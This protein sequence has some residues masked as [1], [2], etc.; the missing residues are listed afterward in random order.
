MDPLTGGRFA[1]RCESATD[2]TSKLV[3]RSRSH[4][5]AGRRLQSARLR[6]LRAPS[7]PSCPS[8]SGSTTRQRRSRPELRLPLFE[9]RRD[10]FFRVLALEQQLLQLALE[11]QALAEPG[12]GPDCTARL[13]RPTARLA[14]C[15]GHELARVVEHRLDERAARQPRRRPRPRSRARAPA[16]SSIDI[17]RPLTISSI[18]RA[19][20][21]SRASRCV[22]PVPGSTPSAT[23][24]RPI[25]P[26]SFCAMRRSA[27]IATS[28]PP[29]TV[30]PF[31]AAITSFGVC[32]SRF[33]VSLA[34]RQK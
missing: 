8:C 20:P 22:P 26:A 18:A 30:W 11:R 2:K 29:P 5:R 12:L 4:N 17:S 13:I 19:L 1:L 3:C 14:L 23:S 21:T 6:D 28:S 33:S 32:S 10:A 16:A 25:L 27:A 24:G 31:S 9:I 7:C 15:G 34:C